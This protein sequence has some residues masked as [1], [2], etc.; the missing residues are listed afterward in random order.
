[1]SARIVRRNNVLAGTFVVASLVLAVGIAMVL[2]DVLGGLGRKNEFTVR[3]PTSV[4]VA[5]VQPGSEVT[6]A[7]LS[8][9]E[10]V[11]VSAYRPAGEAS[12]PEAM[13]VTIS[14]DAGLVLHEDAL[15]DLAPPILGGVSRIN[16]T[17][18]GTGPLPADARNAHLASSNGNGLLEPGE[19]LRGRFA[20]SILTQLGFTVEDAERIRSTIA[21]LEATGRSARD[22]VA[23]VD[24]M[25]ARFEPRLDR[26][27]DDASA[28]VANARSLSERLGEGGDWAGRVSGVLADAERAAA[29]APLLMDDVRS[30]VASARSIVETRAAT[31]DRIL[32]NAER[33]SERM[34]FETLDQAEDLL[35]QGTLALASFRSVG[36][37][38]D[39]MLA[40]L[41]PDVGVVATNARMMSQ[42]ANLFL[43]EIRAQPWRLLKQPSRRDL[44]REPLYAAARAYAEAVADLR[45]ASEALDSAVKTSSVETRADAPME[46]A[47]IADVVEAAY[48]RYADAER[49]LLGALREPAD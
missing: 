34:R 5:G 36:E 38:A 4:G 49:A 21:D 27:L 23:R 45:A 17:S 2:G 40:D 31:I 43:E 33:S 28:V 15:A 46:V 44:E 16:F 35:R 48:A 29:A 24:R 14:V 37:Q 47:R 32:A 7:G 12:P 3:F 6:F 25:A 18:P 10:V 13:D 22:A 11:A 9:G 19:V 39:G 1:M 42:R 20:P 8:V 30:A 41:R 26:T